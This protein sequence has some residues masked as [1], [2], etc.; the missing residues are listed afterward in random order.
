MGEPIQLRDS[1]TVI[2]PSLRGRRSRD[3][4]V[5]LTIDTNKRER[6][7]WA[8]PV[9]LPGLIDDWRPRARVDLLCDFTTTPQ[10]LSIATSPQHGAIRHGSA[11][12]YSMPT[13]EDW[14]YEPRE[15]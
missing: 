7:I 15:H 1:L 14:R 12:K 9:V 11:D 5:D 3:A 10:R 13:S 6:E 2:Y 8:V 4:E